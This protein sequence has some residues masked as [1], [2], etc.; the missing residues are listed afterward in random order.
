MVSSFLL[1]TNNTKVITNNLAEK[2]G[3]N[4]HVSI[5]KQIRPALIKYYENETSMNLSECNN[6]IGC[7]IWFRSEFSLIPTLRIIGN[8]SNSTCIILLNGENDSQTPVQQ[9]FL[10][11]ATKANRCKSS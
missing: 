6:I 8:I 9:A 11:H 3:T 5:Q 7:P 2:F 1:D 4:G 10:L